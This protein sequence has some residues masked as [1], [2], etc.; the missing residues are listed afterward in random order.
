MPIDRKKLLDGR[1]RARAALAHPD[2]PQALRDQF[3]LAL[4]QANAALGLDDS[5][6]QPQNL[7]TKVN[8]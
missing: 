8:N 5:L 6:S 1:E 2:L 7:P 4:D 3:K